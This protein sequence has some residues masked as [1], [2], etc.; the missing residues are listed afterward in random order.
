MFS[1]RGCRASLAV[2]TLRR[3][4]PHSSDGCRSQTRQI[5]VVSRTRAYGQLFP[6]GRGIEE[7]MQVLISA[8]R[9]HPTNNFTL[10]PLH[11]NWREA[12]PPRG[13]QGARGLVLKSR[14][15]RRGSGGGILQECDLCIIVTPGGPE[16]GAS[17]RCRSVGSDSRLVLRRVLPPAPFRFRA[18]GSPIQG[19]WR[20]RWTL[21]GDRRWRRQS[22][23]RRSGLDLW[24]D[25]PHRVVSGERREYGLGDR[26]SIVDGTDVA[27]L[28]L[29]RTGDRD[30][31]LCRGERVSE[32]DAGMP[33][34][35][36]GSTPTTTV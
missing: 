6:K 13:V 4:P 31:S 9:A 27:K 21:T 18:C 12:L 33:S 23:T 2:R 17:N 8:A 11:R 22:L 14:S 15:N 35:R 28:Y 34:D 32:T 1:P 36:G 3:E 5:S 25:S 26:L 19:A 29:L 7:R 24:S 30:Q 20:R 10:L 16:T